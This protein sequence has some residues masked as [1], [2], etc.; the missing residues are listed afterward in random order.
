MDYLGI[1]QIYS[2]EIK[3][4]FRDSLEKVALVMKNQIIAARNKE[5]PCFVTV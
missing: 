5:D 3:E 4:L 1:S 2:S